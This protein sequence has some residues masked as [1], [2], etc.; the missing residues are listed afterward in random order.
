[1]WSAT[2]SC[3]DVGVLLGEPFRRVGRLF[4]ALG[5]LA[6][7]QLYG[8]VEA[9]RVDQRDL[10][11]AVAVCDHAARPA[12]HRRRHRFHHH[13]QQADVVVDLDGDHV[14]LAEPHEQVAAGAV[15]GLV[16]TARTRVRRGLGQRRGVPDRVLGRCRSWRARPLSAGHQATCA[17]PTPHRNTV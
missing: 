9:G 15:G 7:H 4:A 13:P 1:M 5:S 6:S 10:A 12:A 3:G 14:Q 16:M 11:A 2:P 17:P 8:L